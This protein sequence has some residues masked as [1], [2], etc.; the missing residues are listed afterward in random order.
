[1]GRCMGGAWFDAWVVHGWL[2]GLVRLYLGIGGGPDGDGEEVV[3][4][5]SCEME[6]V[7]MKC[8]TLSDKTHLKK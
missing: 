8:E 7:F 4:V 2:P 3:G 6:S 5:V 1:M